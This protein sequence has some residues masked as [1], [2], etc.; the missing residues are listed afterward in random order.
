MKRILIRSG[1]VICGLALSCTLQWAQVPR[2]LNYQGRV[3][4]GGIPFNGSGQFKFA[5]VNGSGSPYWLNSVDTT[6]AD[7]VPD[8]A[9]TLT[10]SRGVYSV[11]L[12][13]ST[14]PN[15]AAVPS[16]VFDNSDVRLRVWFNDGVT[17]FQQLTP[18]QRLAAAPYAINAA[19]GFLWQLVTT[20]AQQAQSN[21]GYL[22]TNDATQVTITLPSAPS[23]GDRVRVSSSGLAGWKIAQNASQSILTMNLDGVVSTWTSRDSARAWQSIASSSDGTKLVAVVNGGQIYTSTDSGATWSPRDNNRSWIAVASS[24]DGVKLVAAEDGGQLYTSVNSGA[25]WTPQIGR[26]HV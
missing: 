2:L 17:G 23:V 20:T 4:A 11:L 19:N 18:D 5:L 7:N 21:V 3:T 1:A 25:N 9:V 10:V 14:V 6:P 15:M 24:S 8:A 16:S 13:D 12:G 26:A 22:T